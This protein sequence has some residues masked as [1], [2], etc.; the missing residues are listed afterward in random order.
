MRVLKPFLPVLV[1]S[2]FASAQTNDQANISKVKEEIKTLLQQLNEARLK[3][4]RK[5]LEN[6]YAPEFI[7]VHSSGFIDDRETTINEIVTTDS[8]RALPISNLDGLTLYGDVAVLRSTGST[9]AGTVISDRRAGIHI[10][11]KKD[12]RWQIA[13]AQGTPLLRERKTVPVDINELK[14]FVG[15]Y[16]R[17]PGEF[18]IVEEDGNALWINVVGRGIP[19]RKLMATSNTDF[20]DKL[21]TEYKFSKDDSGVILSTKLQA[22]QESKWKKR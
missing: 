11:V 12:G 15:K 5:A 14:N 4:D 6:I 17:N 16:E 2:H 18:I 9:T 22:G 21:G 19:K 10:Y 8:I 13:H 20:F 1:F 3:H 7:N